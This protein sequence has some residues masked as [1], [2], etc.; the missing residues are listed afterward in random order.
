MAFPFTRKFRERHPGF[1]RGLA[2]TICFLFAFGAGLAFASWAMVCRAGRCPSA[3]ALQDY[4][5]RQTSK[6]YAADGRFIAE[7]GLER[8][9]LVRYN[10][11]P[12]IVRQAFIDV[13]DKRFFQHS[14]VD[15]AS[16]PRAVAVDLK[17]RNF[18][19]GFSTI[20]MQL[21]RNIF[22]ERISRDKTL[23]RKLKEAKVARDI[24]DRYS[25]DRILELYLNQINLGN[26][27]YGIE[28]ASQRY[29]GKTLKD[30]NLAEVA[31]LAALP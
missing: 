3:A 31:T 9:T 16:V 6:I 21:A 1:T 2:L 8:R 11:I 20:T 10:D 18:A 19:E 14:G 12:P 5:P 13:E 30:L 15:W 27:S 4:E 25:K 26:G 7:L 29:F 24:E 28:S 22:P 17:N 23:I